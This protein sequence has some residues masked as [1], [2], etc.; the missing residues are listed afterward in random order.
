MNGNNGQ[1]IRT[2]TFLDGG[3]I[4]KELITDEALILGLE[5]SQEKMSLLSQKLLEFYQL[6]MFE[7]S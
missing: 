1:L 3:L 6:E 2:D 5:I 7:L 4:E